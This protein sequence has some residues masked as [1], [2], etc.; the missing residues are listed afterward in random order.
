MAQ[1]S[2]DPWWIVSKI[3]TE[4]HCQ[5]LIIPGDK[6][7][8]FPNRRQVECEGC[9]ATTQGMLDDERNNESMHAM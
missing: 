2:R 3:A 4:C 9:G 5:R 8:W 7:L 1:R 6:V